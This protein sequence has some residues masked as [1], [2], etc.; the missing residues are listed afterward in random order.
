MLTKLFKISII[1]LLLITS[2]SKVSTAVDD[3]IIAVVNDEI[4]TLKDLRD[5]IRNSYAGLVAEGVEGEQLNRFMSELETNGLEKLI[6]D[7]LI[8][9]KA[10]KIGLEIRSALVDERVTEIKKRYASEEEFL[11]GLITH[12]ASVTDLRNKIIDQLKIKFVIEHEVK[13]KI[14]ISPKDVTRYYEDNLSTFQ[15]KERAQ[16]DSIYIAFKQDKG[17]AFVKANQALNALKEEA[18]FRE[19]ANKFSDAPSIGTLERGQLNSDIEN[20]IFGLTPDEISPLVEVDSGIYI[21]KLIK[22]L[23]SQTAKLQEV[24]D[25][26]RD[27]LYREKFQKNFMDWLK[28][29][30]KN[31]YIEIKQ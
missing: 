23:A 5:Y 13:S 26:I 2:F 27:L 20:I 22:K 29:L 17:A 11:T 6:E 15:M 14:Y 24:E 7:R 1:S 12:G 21:F 4:I 25:A 31:A 30:K 10:N 3:A 16:L 9:S 28:Q 8:L 18:D 19:V